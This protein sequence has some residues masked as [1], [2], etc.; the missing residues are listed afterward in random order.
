MAANSPA[1]PSSLKKLLL[2]HSVRKCEKNK[3]EET[4]RKKTQRADMAEKS[5]TLSRSAE[6]AH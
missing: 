3:K 2:V 6:G 1:L 4:K 5:T